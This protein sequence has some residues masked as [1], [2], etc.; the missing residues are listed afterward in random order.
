[1][2]VLNIYFMKELWFISGQVKNILTMNILYMKCEIFGDIISRS[3]CSNII[4][5]RRFVSE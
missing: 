4:V 1:M 5:F 2:H 3:F